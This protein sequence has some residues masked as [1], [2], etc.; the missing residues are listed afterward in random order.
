MIKVMQV[1]SDTNVGGAGK[2]LLSFLQNFDK[3]AFSMSLVLPR[4]SELLPEAKKLG[5][6]CF[7]IAGMADKSYD[8]AAIK[9]LIALFEKE[10]PDIVHTHAAMAAR[11]AAR[12]YGRCKI[13]STRHSVFDQ[14]G[15]KKAF[16]AKQLLGYINRRY[17]DVIVAVSP[18]ATE[19]VV[20]TGTPREMVT[21]VFNGVDRARVLSPSE[22][23]EIR[24]GLGLSPD[25]FVCAIIARLEE[26][27][28]HS[29]IIEAAKLLKDSHP[30]I[31]FIIAGSGSLDGVLREEALGLDNVIFTGFIKEIWNIEN[32]MDLNLNASWGTEATSLALLEG[33]SLGVPAVVSDFG[34]NPFV[35]ESGVNGLVV[36]KKNAKALSDA[37]VE[38]KN[39]GALYSTLSEGAKGVYE[40]RF[41]AQAMSRG[42]EAVY[43]GL[44]EGGKQNAN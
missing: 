16:P 31:K 5:L 4:G 34:G 36:E 17:S 28:G 6:P 13:V 26:V 8:R 32:I 20:E 18:A 37:I 15:W 42:I 14:P 39:D 33:M 21:V 11:V 1:I 3:D 38:I 30:E 9:E 22:K 24:R 29:Y 40:G 41:T 12:R 25:D 7:E 10:G 35:I 2:I 43:Y 27:K 44:L 19:N 23:E